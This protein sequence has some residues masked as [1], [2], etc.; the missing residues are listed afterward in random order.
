MSKLSFSIISSTVVFLCIIVYCFS[1]AYLLY[2][3]FYYL[4]AIEVDSWHLYSSSPENSRAAWADPKDK[5][6]LYQELC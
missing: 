6:V 3:P 5:Q 2:V 4:K 1:A